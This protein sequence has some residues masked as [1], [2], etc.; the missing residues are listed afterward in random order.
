MRMQVKLL[1]DEPKK[2]SR[3]ITLVTMLGDFAQHI[4]EGFDFAGYYFQNL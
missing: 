4:N 1:P 2:G 3:Y